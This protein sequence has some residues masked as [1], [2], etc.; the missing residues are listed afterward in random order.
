MT[1]AL[2]VAT[3][4]VVSVLLS[5]L[6]TRSTEASD[7]RRVLATVGTPSPATKALPAPGVDARQFRDRLDQAAVAGSPAL[8]G[9]PWV[10]LPADALQRPWPLDM[11]ERR[12][13][14]SARIWHIDGDC[15]LPSGLSFSAP[16]VSTG[17]LATRPGNRYLALM[18]G[19]RLQI[20]SQSSV[21]SW[22]HADRVQVAPGVEL[23]GPVSADTSL[24]LGRGVR[25]TQLQ[26]P[27]IRS[28]SDPSLPGCDRA[29]Q[30][31]PLEESEGVVWDAAGRCGYAFGAV[32]LAP[33]RCWEGDLVTRQ[34]LT[35]GE[36]S[37]VR[38][39][40][41]CL[42]DLTLRAGC[43]VFG[44]LTVS[45]EIFMA[46]GCQVSGRIECDSLLTLGAGCVLGRPE[47]PTEARAALA[48][49][50]EGVVVH[51][52]LWSGNQRLDI[53][54]A[55]RQG[56]L[57]TMERVGQPSPVAQLV[58]ALQA[59]RASGNHQQAEPG[60][61]WVQGLLT[62]TWQSEAPRA[63]HASQRARIDARHAWEAALT[64]DD[65]L[66]VG[67]GCRGVGNIKAAGAIYLEGGTL[68]LG[69]ISCDG[70]LHMAGGTQVSGSLDSRG[71][72][73]I[74][75]G[76]VVGST[77]RAATV[78]AARVVLAQ[79]AV[80][81]GRIVTGEAGGATAGPVIASTR[82]DAQRPMTDAARA[83]AGVKAA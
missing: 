22:A 1:L 38:G 60:S 46:P 27:V 61:A 66:R 73:Y 32:E 42:G 39:H 55:W 40:I 78:Q 56:Q 18:S 34:D 67:G 82:L 25:Y 11:Q 77:E 75:P 68:L 10:N 6:L 41:R 8:D 16:V 50:G 23:A 72:I 43:S 52:A 69:N 65:E 57:D 14:N 74:G 79:G 19:R 35:L 49:L 30:F 62:K 31:V 83:Q 53:H 4:L 5:Q 44:D 9:V 64:C 29:G 12:H 71:T 15:A 28:L 20:A 17:D 81:H 13:G 45:G 37:Q 51:G 48:Q 63:L 24:H 7:A 21:K 70:D 76:C 58:L 36:G 47:A 33:Q 2:L 80:V 54:P 3:I 26:A 59:P